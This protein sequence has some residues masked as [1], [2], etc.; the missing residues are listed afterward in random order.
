MSVSEIRAL[1]KILIFGNSGSGKSTLAKQICHSEN[2]SHLDLDTLAWKAV[3]PPERKPLK[4]SESEMMHFVGSCNGWVIEG[5]YSDLLERALPFATEI[6]FM[7][8]SVA[9]CIENARNRPWEPHKYD[10]RES[11]DNNLELLIDWISQYSN[12]TDTFSEGAHKSLYRQYSGKK[13]MV[14]GN[15]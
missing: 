9:L 2:L 15:K 5:C 1:R 13:S 8:L 11:Q 7:N 6:I 4:E 12:R 14:I 3:I 10:S